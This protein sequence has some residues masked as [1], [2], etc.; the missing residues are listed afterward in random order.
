MIGKAGVAAIT[1]LAAAGGWFAFATLDDARFRSSAHQRQIFASY[2]P[3]AQC[4]DA[5][6]DPREI[7][8]SAFDY[9]Y[10]FEIRAS[11]A[12]IATLRTSLDR[13]GYRAGKPGNAL[14]EGGLWHQATPGAETVVF[15]FGADG[16]SATWIRD[17]L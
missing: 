11:P 12:C 4:P 15:R 10:N 9:H 16:R 3:D 13:H 6:F 2:V 5:T 1:L 17:K 8:D 7:Q 14:T